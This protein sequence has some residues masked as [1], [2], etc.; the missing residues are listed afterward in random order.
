MG[1]PG[2]SVAKS[3]PAS[4][5]DAG[6]MGSTLGLERVATHSS[7]LAWKTPWTEEPGELQSTGPQR[8]GHD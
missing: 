2:D 5:G 7:V 8:V 1:F 6:D 4:A 3:P